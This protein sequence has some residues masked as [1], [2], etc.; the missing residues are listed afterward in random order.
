MFTGIV[1]NKGVI[2][3]WKPSKDGGRIYVQPLRRYSKVKMG[4]SIALNGCCLTVVGNTNNTLEFDLSDETIRKTA[5][6]KY[7]V[8]TVVN[9]ERAMRAHDALGGH[10]VLGH[11]D[12]VGKVVAIK[13]NRGS[14]EYK[15]QYPKKFAHLLIDKGSVAVD[16]VS[17]TV[18][19][20]KNT[21]FD[22]YIIPHTLK[23]TSMPLYKKGDLVNL[24]YD[25][26]GKYIYRQSQVKR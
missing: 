7:S 16:G 15:I 1:T 21:T 25:V 10:F 14:V 5:F 17:L 26:L 24:E 18:C 3:K 12:S 22:L 20:L 11:V 9:L 6:L 8:G 23:E 19:N 2:K 4:E 13:K